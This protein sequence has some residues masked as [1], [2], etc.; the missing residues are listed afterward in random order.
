LNIYTNKPLAR[1]VKISAERLTIVRCLTYNE[2]M[3]TGNAIAL[4]SRIR[5]K[6]NAFIMRELGS[7][8]LEAIVPSHGD[9]LVSLFSGE[10]YT[11]KE[12]AERIH[13]TKP[14]VT[15]LIDK[16]VE[17]GYVVKEK[18][19]TDNRVTYIKI[20]EKGLALKP[21]FDAISEKLNAIIYGSLTDE[22][23]KYMEDMLCKIFQRL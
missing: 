7:H 6:A 23:A 12:L 18:S 5:E 17:H 9:I 19:A 8:G 15:V 16:L 10:K 4:I 1:G 22:E 3:K 11:M 21:T 2:N 20:T 14:T 13:R